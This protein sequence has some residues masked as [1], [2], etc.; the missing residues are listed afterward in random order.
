MTPF[1]KVVE[2]SRVMT[3]MPWFIVLFLNCA[4]DEN[5]DGNIKNC[6]F[7]AIE[8]VFLDVIVKCF[9]A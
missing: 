2:G 9:D 4:C 1:R 5:V 6:C 3:L 7:C 8:V